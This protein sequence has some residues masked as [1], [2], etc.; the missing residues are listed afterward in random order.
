MGVLKNHKPIKI[1]K[2]TRTC[3]SCRF[4]DPREEYFSF[5]TFIALSPCSFPFL[6]FPP[7]YQLCSIC[8]HSQARIVFTIITGIAKAIQDAK[9]R[10]VPWP[11]LLI[12][13]SGTTRLGGDPVI[14]PVP[15]IF[16]AYAT[17]SNRKLRSV[18]SFSFS[19]GSISTS[20]DKHRSIFFLSSCEAIEDFPIDPCLEYF[21]ACLTLYFFFGLCVVIPLYLGICPMYFF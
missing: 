19:F 7:G 5:M 1:M 9:V 18:S 20:I 11:K 8:S 15:P 14:T 16:A 12:N 17:A 4:M 2:S 10:P 6:T 3:A 13:T 21:D